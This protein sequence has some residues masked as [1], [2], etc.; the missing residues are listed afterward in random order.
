MKLTYVIIMVLVL[1][2]FGC[3]TQNRDTTEQSQAGGRVVIAV[4]DAAN[5]MGTISSIKLTVDQVSIKNEQQAWVD[6]SSEEK[7]YDL[8]KLKADGTNA[9]LVDAKVQAGTYDSIRLHV[10]K[11]EIVDS[12]GTH[13]AKL[14]SNELKLQGK[15]NAQANFTSTAVLDFE[16]DKSVKVTG[17]GNYTMSPVVRLQTRSNAEVSIV[18][19]I[20]NVQGGSV[21]TNSVVSIDAGIGS[22][23]NASSEINSSIKTGIVDSD[24]NIVGIN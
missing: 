7:T 20:V 9:L 22:S 18:N 11:V 24:V 15:I 2:L 17:N 6:I 1:G 16:A 21:L 19:G 4:T 3:E 12:K 23:L 13:E 8:L 10:T 14:P 5:D